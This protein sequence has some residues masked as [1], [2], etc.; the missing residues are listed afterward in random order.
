MAAPSRPSA[1][2]ASTKK[3]EWVLAYDLGGTKVAAG[4]VD[5]SG[6]V[7]TEVREPVQLERGKEAVFE[8]LARLGKQLMAN[9]PGIKRAGI[10]SAGPLD[11]IG[12]VLLDP[13]NFASPSGTWGN[14][15]LASIMTRK[16][17]VPTAL[18]NDAAAAMLAEHWIGAAKGYK[19]AMILTLGT[20]LG[21]GIIC[22]NEL[23]RAGHYFH[24]EAGH[25]ILKMND[26]TAPCGCGNL[27]CAEGYLSGRNFARRA[28]TR[29]GNPSLTGKDI[30]EL[31]RKR[32]PRALAAFD[33]YAHLMAI[34]IHNYV[35]L[36]CPEIVVFTGSFADSAS[37]FMES[38][39]RDLE[40]LLARRRVGVDLLPKLAVSTLQNQAG[41][42][43]GACVAFSRAGK[44]A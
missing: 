40:R 1:N 33:E 8:Q 13:T 28:R 22:N 6:R 24:P 12:G 26:E 9:Y 41:L 20:G 4:V 42:I 18:E 21:T 32:D 37:F 16:L 34:A 35:V 43:G 14:V 31:A 19:N 27:G 30:T 5:S 29:F 44:K 2:G 23:V 17:G 39:R 7:V 10:A 25:I 11:P 3:K 38:T 36:Y 15:P